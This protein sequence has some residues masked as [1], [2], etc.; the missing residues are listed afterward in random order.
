M[1]AIGVIP[2]WFDKKRGAAYGIVASGSSI[3]GVIFP[4]MM[5]RMIVEVGY[6]WAIRTAAFL[7]FLLLILANL[8]IRSRLPP[9][10]TSLSRDA[11][12][13]PFREVKMVLVI[14]GFLL[15]TFGVFVP[16][17]YLVVEAIQG[18]MSLD[19]AQY[20][21]AILNAGRL[22]SH[23]KQMFYVYTN[24]LPCLQHLQHIW[25]RRCWLV[26]RQVWCLQCL[27]R[28]VL[29]CRYNDSWPLDPGCQFCSRN[30]VCSSLW[31]LFWCIC[32]TLGC[33]G[34]QYL[35][36]PAD[37][38]PHRSYLSLLLYRRLDYKSY[39]RSNSSAW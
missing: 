16:I 31:L 30:S 19:L 7:I 36:L 17:N 37:W 23:P 9:S 24:K 10:P 26:C 3:G 33:S 11:L 20:L 6:A 34:C 27:H 21:V 38:L 5:E 2:G 8:T 25:P 4:I 14:I 12:V 13:Q 28:S 1:I 29:P 32:G 15:L 22:V 35:T 18:G 39:S